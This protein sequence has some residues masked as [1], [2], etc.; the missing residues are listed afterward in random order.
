[1]K[2]NNRTLIIFASLAIILALACCSKGDD[3]AQP[4]AKS[5]KAERN[6]IREGN[7]LMEDENYADAEI[8]YSKALQANPQSATAAYNMGLALAKQAAEGDTTGLAQRA[9]SLFN[10][11]AQVT[12]DKKLKAMAYH[13]MGNLSYNAQQFDRAILAYKNALRN[14]PTDDDTRYNLRMAQLKLQQQQQQNQDKN[15]QNQDQQDQQNQDKQNQDQQ[16]QDQDKQDQDKQDQDKQ[17]QQQGQQDKA[18]PEQGKEQQGQ[19]GQGQQGQGQPIN[20]DERS[21]QQVLKAMQDKEKE[22]QQKIYQM[23]EQQRQRERQ[24]TRNRW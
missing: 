9:D 17:D 7:R 3:P 15:Q 12:H 5:T 20:M 18:K 10:F 2:F 13:N 22:T 16:N 1:M 23:G 14:V 8:A 11:A 4:E 24:A 19:Q 21:V 6:F